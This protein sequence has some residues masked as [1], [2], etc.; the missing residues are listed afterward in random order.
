[1]LLSL[2]AV[3]QGGVIPHI[4]KNLIAKTRKKKGKSRKAPTGGKGKK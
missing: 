3:A 2:L 4:H 1:M